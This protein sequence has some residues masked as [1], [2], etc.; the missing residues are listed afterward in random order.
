MHSEQGGDCDV[1]DQVVDLVRHMDKA[2]GCEDKMCALVAEACVI[3]ACVFP[4][5]T[6]E[7]LKVGKPTHKKFSSFTCSDI[8]RTI[9][10]D[11]CHEFPR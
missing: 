1:D 9:F 6:R 7:D 5:F 4:D 10:I 3:Q 2:S 8:D 11:M